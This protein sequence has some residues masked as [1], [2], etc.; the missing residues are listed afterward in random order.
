M[1][2]QAKLSARP[3]CAT[4]KPQPTLS[5]EGEKT[6]EATKRPKLLNRASTNQRNTLEGTRPAQTE[7]ALPTTN[8]RV[9]KN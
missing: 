3:V 7:T 8:A 5:D 9:F 6:N 4:H 2:P 1:L